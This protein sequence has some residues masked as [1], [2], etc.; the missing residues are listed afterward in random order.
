MNLNLILFIFVVFSLSACEEQEDLLSQKWSENNTVNCSETGN[1]ILFQ[2]QGLFYSNAVVEALIFARPKYVIDDGGDLLI[3]PDYSERP[4]QSTGFISRELY[5]KMVLSG[6]KL[7][8]D[9]FYLGDKVIT[10]KLDEK[11]ENA[12]KLL[13]LVRCE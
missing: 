4:S 3:Y 11:L 10:E 1:Y 7:N 12:V 5:F 13:D 2:E 8:F 6:D 9:N